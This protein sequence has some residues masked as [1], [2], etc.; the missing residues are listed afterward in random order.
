MSSAE[1]ELD[2]LHQ[3]ILSWYAESGHLDPRGLSNHLCETGFAG[4]VKQLVARGPQTAWFDQDGAACGAVL[5]GWR[6]CVVRHRHFAE[7]RARPRAASAAVAEQRDDAGAWL[8]AVNRL[9]NPV[10][11]A[12]DPL[13]PAPDP[14]E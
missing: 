2:S 8:M 1:P 14:N 7:R 6:A 10:D 4:L 3:A 11:P 12:G 5:D 13:R 9:L